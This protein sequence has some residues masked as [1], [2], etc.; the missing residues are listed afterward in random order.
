MKINLTIGIVIAVVA[1]AALAVGLTRHFRDGPPN[2]VEMVRPG[3]GDKTV[4]LFPSTG[5][6]YL[7]ADETVDWDTTVEAVNWWIAQDDSLT[8]KLSQMPIKFRQL[9]ALDVAKKRGYFLITE[10]ELPEGKC[11]GITKVDYD[12]AT[13]E[14][15]GGTIRIN[16]AH[17]Y[18]KATRVWAT[19][20]ELGHALSL[21]DDPA[22]GIDLNSVMRQK[23]N[24]GGVLVP[25]DLAYLVMKRST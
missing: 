24:I 22:P 15:W 13:G 6:R 23:L 11:G 17:S 16:K 12:K 8:F 19:I 10:E 2:N 4:S 3:E 9:E 14:I 25:E 18:N 21:E 1:I 5:T 7:I 20:H